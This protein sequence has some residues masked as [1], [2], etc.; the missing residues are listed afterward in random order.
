MSAS[1]SSRLGSIAAKSRYSE[2]VNGAMIACSFKVFRRFLRSGSILEMGPAEGMMTDLLAQ[3]G[4]PLTV[5]EGA[6]QFCEAI[7]ERHPGATVVNSLFETFEPART[8]DNIVLGH[9]LEHVEDPVGILRRA[10]A[11]L[12]PRGRILAA[13][14]NARSLHRQAGV[15]MGM[16]EIE[17]ALNDMDR[18]HGHRRVYDPE[19][20]RA[21]FLKS[22]LTIEIFG[23]YWLKPVSNSQIEAAWSDELL[24]AY[25]TLGE[26]YPDIASEIYVIA[27]NP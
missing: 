17:S 21:D 20:F 9:V 2:G 8:F 15:L 7:A 13:V 12:S 18:Y 14:P 4:Q 3:L 26:R 5:V 6:P 22:G 1:E 25:M 11:W 23:G 27:Q 19:S 24:E 16:L 10:A